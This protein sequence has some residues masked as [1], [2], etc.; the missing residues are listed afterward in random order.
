MP[1]PLPSGP[2]PEAM[3]MRGGG[4][5]PVSDLEALL[6]PPRDSRHANKEGY[7]RPWGT[8]RHG[9]PKGTGPYRRE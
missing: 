7:S 1:P 8:N 4:E 6:Q 5:G 3:M 9:R 2:P